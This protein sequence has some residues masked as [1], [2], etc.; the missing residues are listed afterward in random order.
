MQWIIFTKCFKG[1]GDE[2]QTKYKL[3]LTR[4]LQS[5]IKWENLETILAYKHDSD[6][7]K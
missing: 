7:M 4:C 2:A 1:I 3:S 5:Y 6:V